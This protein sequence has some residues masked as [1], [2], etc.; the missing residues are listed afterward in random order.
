MQRSS[1]SGIQTLRDI[2]SATR[3]LAYANR[4]SSRNEIIVVT[5]AAPK[6]HEQF[7]DDVQFER[8]GLDLFVESHWSLLARG[9]FTTPDVY[10]SWHARLNRFGLLEELD[11]V[12]DYEVS[13]ER[14]IQQGKSESFASAEEGFDPIA[15]EILRPCL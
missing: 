3:A 13:Y 11:D 9:V 10:P 12:R 2:K 5:S 15:I 4:R 6:G 7:D 8:L 14:A 1:K